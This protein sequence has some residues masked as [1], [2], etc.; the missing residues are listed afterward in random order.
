MIVLWSQKRIFSNHLSESLSSLALSNE[1]TPIFSWPANVEVFPIGSG[2]LS[3]FRACF[4]NGTSRHLLPGIA[5]PNP[6]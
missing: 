2:K 3:V 1:L 5:R 6:D 4:N